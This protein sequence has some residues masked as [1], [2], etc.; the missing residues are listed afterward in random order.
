MKDIVSIS[1]QYFSAAVPIPLDP[2]DR[3]AWQERFNAWPAML[4]SAVRI[5]LSHQLAVRVIL[6]EMKPFHLGGAGDASRGGGTAVNG[7]VVAGI[8]D[9]ALGVA[10]VIQFPGRRAATVDLSIKLLRPVNSPASAFGWTVRRAS[11][12]AF[13]EAILIDS[14]GTRC[15]QASG[16]VCAAENPGGTQRIEN[17]GVSEPCPT[18]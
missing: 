6:D 18:Y 3:R 4:H 1:E 7:G 15:A 2:D 13:V 14:R 11:S 12:M 5:D 16:I 17:V 9:C 8:F 10:G